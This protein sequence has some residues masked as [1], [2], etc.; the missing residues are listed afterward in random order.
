MTRVTQ[1]HVD[2]RREAILDAAAR[3]FARNGT[4]RTTMAEIAREAD[5]SA[6][7]IYRYF[8]SKEEL[9]HAVFDDAIARNQELFQSTA[10][11]A[12]TPMQALEAVGRKVWIELD[13]RDDLLCDIQMTLAG[14]RDPDQ[15]GVEISRTWVALRAMLAGMIRDAQASGELDPDVDPETL[16]VI[17]QACT[18]GIQMMK[19]DTRNKVDVEAALNLF[20]DMI[21][22]LRGQQRSETE[23]EA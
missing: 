3:L 22:G 2:A 23:R 11:S 6:G 5:L 16:A 8:S 15:F 7:A 14:A 10:Q 12:Q 19:L 4:T 18:S 20:V 9:V 13:D 17:L 21:L 1:Q